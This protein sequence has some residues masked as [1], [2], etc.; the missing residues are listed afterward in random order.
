[1]IRK[2]IDIVLSVIFHD[3][4]SMDLSTLTPDADP[5]L[6][7]GPS[8]P[9]TKVSSSTRINLF[10]YI[11]STARENAAYY[12]TLSMAKEPED[13]KY[14]SLLS[15]L[16]LLCS[17]IPEVDVQCE[18]ISKNA[19]YFDVAP[20]I[21]GNGYRSLLSIVDACLIKLLESLLYMKEHRESFYFRRSKCQ[22][23]IGD[24]VEVLGMMRAL[25][26]YAEKMIDAERASGQHDLFPRNG[27]E[28]L[29][30]WM[31]NV[32]TLNQLCFYGNC[33]AFYLCPSI[34]TAMHTVIT[35]AL[36][37]F[38][39]KYQQ[40]EEECPG[41]GPQ[42]LDYLG[43]NLVASRKF[44]L[45]PQLKAQVLVASTRELDIR[46]CKAFW[47]ISES[48]FWDPIHWYLLPKIDLNREFSIPPDSFVLPHCDTGADV[49]VSPPVCHIGLRPVQCRLMS[50][51]IREGQLFIDNND[52]VKSF[53]LPG[54]VQPKSEVLLF[55]LHGGGF[56]SQSSKACD[57]YLREWTKEI[58]VPLLSIDYT[59]A[60]EAPYPRAIEECFFAYCW[61]LKYPHKLGWT[62]QRIVLIGD[63]AGGNLIF[64]VAFKCFMEGIRMPSGILAAYAPFLAQY[65][66]SPSRLLAIMDPLIPVGILN[67]CLG[68]YAGL[69]EPNNV[70][71][72]QN[73]THDSTD[74]SP[75]Q[76]SKTSWD[77]LSPSELKGMEEMASFASS[78]DNGTVDARQHE[79]QKEAR[80]QEAIKAEQNFL[81]R[82]PSAQHFYSV[83]SPITSR[84]T[85]TVS[86]VTG[87]MS[88]GYQGIRDTVEYPFRRTTTFARQR[89]K[90]IM[91]PYAPWTKMMSPLKR[92]NFS[93]VPVDDPLLSPVLADATLLKALP[94]VALVAAHVDPFLDDTVQLAK[95]LH[96]LDK[97]MTMD[98]IPHLP[99]G[100]LNFVLVS[101]EARQGNR[102]L[103]QRVR[104]LMAPDLGSYG[105]ST[106]S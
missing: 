75:S 96:D 80:A 7:E 46:F 49:T 77:E 69:P 79:K 45:N 95:R 57:L 8:I 36:A 50:A 92:Y 16:A 76:A 83:A 23:E 12:R 60:P 35:T 48:R 93:Q 42:A 89:A 6:Q 4:A 98:L 74:S 56:I 25:L 70:G 33:T 67:R 2:A 81:F 62:G 102:I 22:Q 13:P 84:L 19:T 61:A 71:D 43:R 38:A 3:E 17:H 78:P 53:K 91:N 68:A 34:R 59:L 65:T 31:V 101:E 55:H 104:E 54:R 10:Q 88:R 66:P 32:E 63:S 18:K 64:G 90:S 26:N 47:S 9:A 37:T 30:E 106:H 14:T 51:G 41:S 72:I 97:A 73:L 94:P 52:G 40:L 100:F 39:E 20:N 44:I 21:E 105:K 103:M 15:T 1:M 87:A 85:S 58:G 24:Y 5:P 27:Q 11:L 29:D 86:R 28:L 82:I 99:H